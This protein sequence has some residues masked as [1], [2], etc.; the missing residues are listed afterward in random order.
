MSL[1]EEVKNRDSVHHLVFLSRSFHLA[2]NPDTQSLWIESAH[3]IVWVALPLS[4]SSTSG[5]G[6]E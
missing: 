4:E 6:K 5:K 1:T 2:Q 3:I